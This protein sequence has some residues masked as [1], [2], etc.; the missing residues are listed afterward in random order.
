MIIGNGYLY[1]THPSYWYFLAGLPAISGLLLPFFLFE[2][3]QQFVC[4]HGRQNGCFRVLRIL[5]LIIACY[6]SMHSISAHKEFR[7]ILPILPIVCVISG[8]GM[9]AFTV[10]QVNPSS[11]GDSQSTSK[12]YRIIILCAFLSSANYG[13]LLFLCRI[14]QRAPLDINRAIVNFIHAPELKSPLRKHYLPTEQVPSYEIHYLMGCH[15]TPLFSHLHIP[16]QPINAWTLDCSPSCRS[17]NKIICESNAFEADPKSF[18]KNVYSHFH[19]QP[20]RCR[21]NDTCNSRAVPDFLAV[22]DSSSSKI[23]SELDAMGLREILRI[24]HAIQSVT[25]RSLMFNAHETD[26]NIVYEDFPFIP[27]LKVK[28]QYMLLYAN[29]NSFGDVLAISDPQNPDMNLWEKSEL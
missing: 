10:G 22:F 9:A 26:K 16:R 2:F 11:K 25:F 19:D 14:H 5:F 23:Q 3:K 20:E 27:M 12:R 29:V 4:T 18:V 1:G 15:S 24:K 7:F 28:F 21:S 8:H 6:V 13:A 17:D